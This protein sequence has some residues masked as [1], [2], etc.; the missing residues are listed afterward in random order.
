MPKVRLIIP[1]NVLKLFSA[2]SV[3]ENCIVLGVGDFLSLQPLNKFCK[4]LLTTCGVAKARPCLP[5]S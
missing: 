2:T 4:M 1:T 3:Q 5:R